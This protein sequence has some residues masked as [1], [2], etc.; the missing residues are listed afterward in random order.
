[1]VQS[2]SGSGTPGGS[3]TELQFNDAGAFDGTSGLTWDGTDL[4]L[5]GS[6]ALLFRGEPMGLQSPST[7]VLSLIGDTQTNVYGDAIK[8]FDTSL[9]ELLT[10]ESVASAVNHLNV[11]SSAT[12]GPPILEALGT[13]TNIGLWILPKGSGI[14]YLG[15]GDAA[16]DPE[17]QFVGEDN[18]GILRWMEDEDY[19]NFRDGILMQTAEELYFRATTQRIYSPAA[20][21]LYIDAPVLVINNSNKQDVVLGADTFDV[22]PEADNS[23]DLGISTKR[24]R[25]LPLSGRLQCAKGSDVASAGTLTLGAGGN[26]F[27]ITGTTTINYITTTGWQTGSFVILQF[28]ASV[29]VAHNTGSVPGSTAALLLSG[30][31]NF[32]ATA[33]DTL[34][35]WYDGTNWREV[36]RT[37]I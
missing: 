2:A 11:I 12:L 31:A 1:M 28:D 21:Q 23:V 22:Y 20:T 33:G 19:F 24:Y 32:S 26:S 30:A 27:D 25:D 37:V 35:L 10:L 17:L 13:D 18:S 15:N 29:T 4:G 14:V 34:M 16:I 3:T 5:A 8:F 6:Q 7:G 36:S 9:N